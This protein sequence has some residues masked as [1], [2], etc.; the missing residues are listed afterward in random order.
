L[1]ASSAATSTVAGVFIGEKAAAGDAYDMEAGTIS[2]F[3]FSG[4]NGVT[5]TQNAQLESDELTYTFDKAKNYIISI[6][7]SAGGVKYKVIA[8]SGNYFLGSASASAGTADVT[9]Y[10]SGSGNWWGLQKFTVVNATGD[11]QANTWAATAA[12]E[13]FEVWF[14]SHR[15]TKKASLVTL[16]AAYDYFWSGGRLYTYVAD[17]SDPDT[18]YAVVEAAQRDVGIRSSANSYITIDGIQVEKTN[19]QGIIDASGNNWT[20]MNCT[21]QYLGGGGPGGLG[22]GIYLS[23]NNGHILNNT[24]AHIKWYG[25]AI[26][27]TDTI[28]EYNTITDAWNGL[29]YPSSVGAGVYAAGTNTIVRYNNVVESCYGIWQRGGNGNINYNLIYHP[30]VNGIASDEDISGSPS[31][32]SNNT[33]VHNPAWASGH[34]MVIQLLGDGVSWRNNIV[35]VSYTGINTNVQAYCIEKTTYTTIHL[36]YNLAFKTGDSTADLYKMNSTNYNTLADWKTALAGTAYSGAA[37][38]DVVAD[39]LFVSAA[40]GDFHLQPGSPARG[41]GV[42]VGLT[43]DYYGVAVTNPPSMG[44]SDGGGGGL[45]GSFLA[46]MPVHRKRQRRAG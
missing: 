14:D 44:A 36:D 16:A 46:W 6:G 28:A 4:N 21:V 38:H 1:E 12:I 8:G 18:K 20:V 30:L 35:Y 10:A 3:K 43:T 13:P 24:V 17:D 11:S 23:G 15:G 27:G 25:L 33:I 42:S 31:S 39:P 32:I 9:G 2:Q 34:G 19:Y 40:T 7:V 41:A 29:A 45:M 5:I 26:A 22:H 37:A